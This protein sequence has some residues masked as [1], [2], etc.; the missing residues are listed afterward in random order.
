MFRREWRQQFLVIALLTVAAAAAIASVTIAYNSSSAEDADFGSASHLIRFDGTDPDKLEAGLA[1]TRERFGTIDVIGHGSLRVPGSVDP[2]E[3]RSQDPHGPYGDALLALRRGSYPEGPGQVA[4]TDGVA[5]LLGL[6]IGKP[7]ALDGRRWTVVGIVENPRDLSGEFAL[8]SPSS[9]GAPDHVTVLVDADADSVDTFIDGP[10]DGVRLG[11]AGAE[12]RQSNRGAD[13]LAMFSVATVFLLLATLVAAA[14]FAVIA[15]RRLRQLGALAA[16]GATEKHLRLVLLTNGA[17]V[18]AI[19]ALIGAIVG[20]AIWLA[21]VPTLEPAFGH[22][23]DP[24][25]LPWTLLVAIVFVA[26]LGATAAAWWPG[27]VVARIPVTLALSARPPKP[28]P[29]HHSTILAAVL[30]AAGIG[31][32]ALSERDSAPLIVAGILATI[33]GTLLLGPLAIRLFARAA[34]HVPIAPRLAL[35][36]LARYQARSGAALAAITLALGIAAAVVIVAAAEEKKSA[37]EP[38]NLSNRQ[39]RV[40]SGAMQDPD[41][42]PVQTSAVL[43][44]NAARVRE[45][46]AG[47][48]DAAVTSLQSAFYPGFPPGVIDGV[49]SRDPETLRRKID[50]PDSER[51]SGRGI[52]GLG[53]GG[54]C[55]VTESRLYVAT[56]ALLRSLGVDPAAVD[57]STD[58][59]ADRSV[60]TDELVTV[61]VPPKALASQ[62]PQGTEL[63][64]T[65]VQRIDSQ[66]RFG[67]PKGDR[68]AWT[69]FITLDG[70]RRRG[71]RQIPSGWLVESNRPLTSE[72]IADARELAAA[73]GLTIETQREPTS[74]AKLSAIA[75][76]AGAL[77]ALAILAMTVGLIRSETAG[78]LRTLSAAGATSRIRRTLTAATAG[79]LALLGALLGVAGAYVVVAAT[80]LDDLGYLSRI[81]VLYVVLM[82][83]GVPLAAA[84]A[85]WLLAG[86]EPPAIARPAIE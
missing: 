41:F 51:W 69:S 15:Q 52:L 67:S 82:V 45:L 74:Q 61:T 73:A 50:D 86:R 13:T 39:I 44:R 60:P 26:V 28:R 56:P 11:F 59:L 17:V 30:I 6:E 12:A 84:G 22:R 36:D 58:F 57:P 2:V 21:L 18:G 72:Q 5:T 10:A 85:G 33:V 47:L 77:L 4:V 81:P 79:G 37:G 55:W 19:G 78:D 40:Y 14:G 34:G 76:A 35:R 16:I 80:Y 23:I 71:W 7:L 8:V 9:A 63:P 62:E 32:L 64:V 49:R 66:K 38:Q 83:V 65:N 42:I 29:T 43:E 75:T 20:L 27:R 24:L 31:S 3:L 46:A 70:L 54:C 68:T 48:D 1:A 53:P 25:T